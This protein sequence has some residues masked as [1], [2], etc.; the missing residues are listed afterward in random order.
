MDFREADP[1]SEWILE[2]L[3]RSL[4][5]FWSELAR[6]LKL[7]RSLSGFWSKLTRSMSGFCSELT[8]V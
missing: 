5:G 1:K 8:E 2:K 7:T 4:S 3:T 6:S